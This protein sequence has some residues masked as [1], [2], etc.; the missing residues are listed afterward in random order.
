MDNNDMTMQFVELYKNIE[1]MD[2]NYIRSNLQKYT[3]D[4]NKLNE[5]AAELI[6]TRACD[7]QLI[8]ND[9]FVLTI[10]MVH[11]Y[12]QLDDVLNYLDLHELKNIMNEKH[13]LEKEEERKKRK[14]N[15]AE[16][17][18]QDMSQQLSQF[19]NPF[20]AMAS[21]FMNPFMGMNGGM[22]GA[23]NMMPG[24]SDVKY[25]E[26]SGR[27]DALRA[28]LTEQ[29]SVINALYG[30][31]NKAGEPLKTRTS[32]N[33]YE[34][35]QIKQGVSKDSSDEVSRLHQKIELLTNSLEDAEKTIETMSN[36]QAAPISG[37]AA[38]MAQ[39]IQSL[40]KELSRT[41][42]LAY[43][44]NKYNVMNTNAYTN[45]LA[46]CDKDILTIAVCGIANTRQINQ[47]YG[48]QSGDNVIRMVAE[49]LS[50]MYGKENVYRNYGDQFFLLL[51][52][53]NSPR[54]KEQLSKLQSELFNEKISIS[55]GVVDAVTCNT[56]EMAVKQA[57][58]E[59]N[60]MKVKNGSKQIVSKELSKIKDQ[61][62]KPVQ[63]HNSEVSTPKPA[64]SPA[65]SHAPK[66]HEIKDE[67][68][69]SDDKS[70]KPEAV[71]RFGAD[72]IDVLTETQIQEMDE[73]IVDMKDLENEQ[74]GGDAIDFNDD[75]DENVEIPESG[76][77][78]DTEDDGDGGFDLFEAL[79][80]A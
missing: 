18:A 9:T 56:I 30:Q 29:R 51:E 45:Y 32:Y 63:K 41:K 1:D 26:L 12:V 52:N 38:E 79:L 49:R 77:V 69:F 66:E 53:A 50:E 7:Y 14:E 78:E 54:V 8:D 72:D 67:P 17:T 75:S 44:D 46:N 71:E 3:E 21:C 20:A 13:E 25:M 60:S 28:E 39:K 34:P 16:N 10:D 76:A 42:N 74:P 58:G 65:P 80:D 73:S 59:M 40:E 33:K 19:M 11:Y 57:E 43:T 36:N 37:D 68:L 70:E 27:I 2:K 24:M 47:L 62:S 15:K 6:R 5:Y 61:T 31:I 22:P 23:S 35:G 4:F 55:F 48:R 64:P